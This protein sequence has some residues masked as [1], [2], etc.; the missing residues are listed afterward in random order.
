MEFLFHHFKVIFHTLHLIL[1]NIQISERINLIISRLFHWFSEVTDFLRQFVNV[2]S[3]M[4]FNAFVSMDIALRIENLGNWFPFS[5]ASICFLTVRE[6]YF[7]LRDRMIPWFIGWLID[8][9]FGGRK[10]S[11]TQL[12]AGTSGWAGLLSIITVIFLFWGPKFRSTTLTLSSNTSDDNQHFGCAHF[13][14]L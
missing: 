4:E 11:S 1:L 14:L 5:Q 9:V 2:I 6:R 3:G 13:S 12:S 7:A 8:V 10:I